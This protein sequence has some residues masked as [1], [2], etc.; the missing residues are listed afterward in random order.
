MFHETKQAASSRDK[1]HPTTTLR[2]QD[3]DNFL[4]GRSTV[5]TFQRSSSTMAQIRPLAYCTDFRTGK[6]VCRLVL[7]AVEGLFE[8]EKG[9]LLREM[10][11]ATDQHILDLTDPR[12]RHFGSAIDVVSTTTIGATVT[13]ETR[14]A[15]ADKITALLETK[16]IG[17]SLLS[18]DSIHALSHDT[19]NTR[20][21][22]VIKER[23]DRVIGS[24]R[25]IPRVI[26]DAEDDALERLTIAKPLLSDGKR[27]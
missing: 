7:I 23:Y 18:L 26:A 14:N 1:A 19:A 13:L 27:T 8:K 12:H 11:Y 15:Y 24:K 16:T 2:A 10:R 6:R 25:G 22:A 21:K 3:Y 5:S 17:F 20:L 4:S 9:G